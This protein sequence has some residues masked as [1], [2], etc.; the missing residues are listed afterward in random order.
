MHERFPS[1]IVYQYSGYWAVSC[2]TPALT[3]G[4][5]ASPSFRIWAIQEA[6]CTISGSLKPRVVT[7]GVPMRNDSPFI[8]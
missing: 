8:G 7:A 3:A 4:T 1:S 6:I 5:A 2:S